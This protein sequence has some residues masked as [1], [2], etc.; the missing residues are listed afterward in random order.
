MESAEDLNQEQIELA[1]GDSTTKAPW[2]LEQPEAWRKSVLTS[3][4]DEYWKNQQE[5]SRSIAER[6]KQKYREEDKAGR[7]ERAR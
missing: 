1:I 6:I 4:L 2:Y 3:D 5:Q 7:D